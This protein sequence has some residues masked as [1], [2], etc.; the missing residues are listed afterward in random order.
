MF[1]KC[2]TIGAA[3]LL[4]GCFLKADT[5]TAR[6]ACAPEGAAHRCR[7]QKAAPLNDGIAE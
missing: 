3:L 1:W 4:G 6:I 2:G 5:V 7:V